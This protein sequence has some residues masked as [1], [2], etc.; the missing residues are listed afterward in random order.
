MTRP[1][2]TSRRIERRKRFS[3]ARAASR[4]HSHSARGGPYDRAASNREVQA[5]L[6]N[7]TE[8]AEAQRLLTQAEIDDSLA[9]LGV[10]RSL[11]GVAAAE[12]DLTPSWRQQVSREGPMRLVLAALTRPI[13]A[14][15]AV[16]AVALCAFLALRSMPVDIFPNLGAPAIYVAQPYGGMDPQQMEGYLTYYFEYHFLYIT[17]SSTSRARTFR[18]PPL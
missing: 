12:G 16:V 15:V 7:I 14:V 5:G 17:A 8:V 9:R 3:K 18:A 4:K 10:W 11:L 13:S 2:K 6:G 1:C